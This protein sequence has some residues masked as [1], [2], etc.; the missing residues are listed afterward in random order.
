MALKGIKVI[1]IA[2]LAPGPFCGMILSDFG[3]DVIRVDKANAPPLDRQARGKRSIAL[4]L[5]SPDGIAILHRLC[6]KA[7]VLIE[8]FRPGV[9]EKLGLG[10]ST[11]LSQNPRLIYAR[12]TGFGQSGPYSLMAG[13]DINYV[14]LTGLLSLLGRH[15]SNPIP[16]QNLLADFAGGGLLCAMGIAMA[17][18]ERERSNMGQ[19]IDASMVEGAAYVGS[20][21]FKSQDMPVWS[22]VRG[23]SW[24]DGGVHY[25][26]TYKTKDGKYMT[27][28]ALEP[29]FYQELVNQLANAGVEN[30]PDQFPDD[31]EV[32]KNQ[33]ADIF[34]QKTRAEW[35]AIFDQ[36]DACVTPVLDL[37]E[38]PLHQHNAFR[39]S[40]I[41]NAKGQCDPAPAPRLSRTPALDLGSIEEPSIGENTREVLTEI[42]YKT[43]EIKQLIQDKV[44]HQVNSSAKL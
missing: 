44:V 34:L 15:G 18:F 1:E 17:L 23:K 3:A 27:V 43:D 5:K 4:N 36:T 19:I 13:H 26:E 12:L 7:D 33:M 6:S 38:A 41:R 11:L 9:M 2:G 32:A 35:Q 30:V 29:Q 37:G 22:G 14:A 42:G 20:W 8:P 28:G 10:P 24:F 21:I 40:F 39:G 16:P 31:P 25:Y